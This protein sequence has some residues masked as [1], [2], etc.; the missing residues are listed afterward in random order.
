MTAMTDTAWVQLKQLQFL[1]MFLWLRSRP[2]SLECLELSCSRTHRRFF[3]KTCLLRN[4]EKKGTSTTWNSGSINIHQHPW[5]SVSIPSSINIHEPTWIP[6]I[7]FG[8]GGARCF[9]L[10]PLASAP[11]QRQGFCLEDLRR[12][13]LSHWASLGSWWLFRSF[14]SL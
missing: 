2:C 12:I 7:F 5:T 10:V 6:A 4:V 9:L 13:V 11:R 8:S 14:R 3:R 1:S